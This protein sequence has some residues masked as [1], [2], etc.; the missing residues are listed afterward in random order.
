M[1][2]AQGTLSG[3]NLMEF[4]L[5]N[6]PELEPKYQSS[7][8]DQLNL[9]YRYKS[10]GLNTR[11]EQYYPSFGEDISYVR[12][13]QFKFQYRSDII[14]VSVGHLYESLGKGLLLRTYEIPSSIWESRGYRVRYGF[15]RD[16]L[17][18]SVNLK[19]KKA[20][21]KLLRGE[22]LD[23]T[24]PPTL[25]DSER[26]PDLMEGAEL[27]YRI[28]AQKLGAIFARHHR[29]DPSNPDS[30]PTSYSS[31]YFDG[32]IGENVSLYGEVAKR[33]NDDL[34]L[35]DFGEDAAFGA[36]LGLNF[37]LGSFGGSLEFKDY[38][39]FLLGNGINDPPT[40]VKE[41]SYRLLNRSTHIPSLANETGYQIEIYYSS[42][43]GNI[44][45]FNH[46][47]AENEIS[48]SFKPIFKEYF[49]EY[50]FS[51][52]ENFSARTFVDYSEAPFES[53]D[54]RYA[55]GAN[56]NLI[57]EKMSSTIE[58]EVQSIE[59]GNDDIFANYYLAYTLARA[60]KYSISA[61]MELSADPF[62]LSD[63]DDDFN[64]Y[65]AISASYKPNTKNTLILFAGKRRGGPSCN[66]GVCYDVLSFQGVE[67]RLTT[68]F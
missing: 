51:L 64:F 14:D 7:L 48:E 19:Y 32:F 5:G 26:R 27:S 33:V 52:S 37:F 65:P 16:L 58:F 49:L 44:L 12:L 25:K 38:Q 67:L 56:L 35:Y 36:Y 54:H 34:N 45:T 41:H 2:M 63:P 39:N 66:S 55:T 23:V 53:E 31:I 42:E 62:V 61:L 20:E 15:Y 40:L 59:R 28:G 46:S 57:H 24:L 9:S 3:S 6:I 18:A 68:R 13:S 30:E 43:N 17:G 47:R 1:S 10:F 8:Y 60:S 21:L 50:Q 11:I 4:Q 29:K 22:V